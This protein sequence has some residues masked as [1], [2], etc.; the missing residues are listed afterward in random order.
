[1]FWKARVKVLTFFQ[2]PETSNSCDETN[3]NPR[4]ECVLII[5]VYKSSKLVC[6]TVQQFSYIFKV[7]IHLL[8]A[9]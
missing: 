1:M 2:Q 9:E 6:R 7:C 8:L 5:Q 3:K 4:A